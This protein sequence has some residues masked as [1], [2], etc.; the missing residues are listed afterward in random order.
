MTGAV[1]IEIFLNFEC[2]LLRGPL[3]LNLHL[4]QKDVF[5]NIARALLADH[6]HNEAKNTTYMP[7]EYL[8]SSA[9]TFFSDFFSAK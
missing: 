4:T 3:V 7:S 9:N 8:K 1:S 6:L 5:W 2:H